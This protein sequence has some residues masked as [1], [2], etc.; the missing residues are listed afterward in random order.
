MVKTSLWAPAE[1]WELTPEQRRTMCTGCGTASTWWV[2]DTV[3]GLNITPACNIHDYMYIMGD[4]EKDRKTAD[5]VFLN[6]IIRIIQAKTRFRILSWLRRRRAVI[7]YQAVRLF[8]GAAFWAGKNKPA[9]LET[10]EC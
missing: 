1:Y 4:C 3:W 9:E 10:I 7:Y 5:Q 8:G 6:N 2:P